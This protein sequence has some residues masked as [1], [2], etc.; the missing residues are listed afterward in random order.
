[1]IDNPDETVI[2]LEEHPLIDNI[3]ILQTGGDFWVGELIDNEWQ[4]LA[5][6]WSSN[7]VGLAQARA[8]LCQTTGN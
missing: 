5:G 8:T 7:N 1:M 4:Y 3:A 2:L 6:Y